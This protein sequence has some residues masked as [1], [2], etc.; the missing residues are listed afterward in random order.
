MLFPRMRFVPLVAAVVTLSLAGPPARQLPLQHR[1]QPTMPSR[2]VPNVG[3]WAPEVLGAVLGDTAAWLHA[4]GFSLRCERRA[5]R[6]ADDTHWQPREAVG[7]QLRTRF[8]GAHASLA[9]EQPQPTM[10]HFLLGADATRHR[11]HVP[12]FSRCTL[13]GIAPG[14]DVA[15]GPLRDAGAGPFAY[16]LLLA[17]GASLAEL[18]VQIEGVDE[19]WLDAAGQL[20]MRVQTEAGA[21][22][23]RHSAPVAWQDDGNVRKPVCAQF[24]LLDQHCYGFTVPAHDS[25]LPLTVDP[26][27]V[28]C[29][30]LGG[31]ATD[32][33]NDMTWLPGSGIWVAGWAGSTN[34][35][36]TTGAY[37]TTGGSDCFVARWSEDGSQLLYAT[38]F[39][40]SSSEEVRGIAVGSGREPAIVGFTS[41]TDLPLTPNAA[42]PFYAGGSWVLQVGDAFAARLSA[43]GS[44][45]LGSTYLGGTLDDVAED[46]DVDPAGNIYIAGW[47]SSPD[48]ITTPGSWQPAFGGP[49]TLQTD[50]FLTSLTADCTTRRY[51]TYVGGFAPEQLRTVD[52]DPATGQVVAAGWS[53]SADFPTTTGAYRTS[54]A[55]VI[56]FVAL[57][58]R[59]D[60]SAPLFSTYFGGADTD[61]AEACAVAND[62]TLWVGGFTRSANFTTTAGAPQQQFGG[63]DDGAIIRLAADGQSLLYSTFLGGPGAEEVRGLAVEGAEVVAVGQTTGGIPNLG[64]LL[65]PQFGGGALDGFVAW[66]T[67][68]GASLESCTYIG[69]NEQDVLS[70]V[71]LNEGLCVASGWTFASDFPTTSNA[72][73]PQVF[74]AE[75]GVVLQM[76]VLSDLGDGLA[77]SSLGGSGPRLITEGE[78]ELVAV[79]AANQTGRALTIDSLRLLLA[80]TGHGPSVLSN[81]RVYVDDPAT[82]QAQDQLVAGPLAVMVEDGEQDIALTG[83]VVPRL[84]EVQLRVVADVAA[85]AGS[86]VEVAAAI[87]RAA[88]WSVSAYGSGAGPT[89]RV[90][91]DGRVAGEVAVLGALPGDADGDGAR[92]VFDLRRIVARLGSASLQADAD[93][94]GAWT[95]VDLDLTTDALLARGKVQH[96][97]AQVQRGQFVTLR[98]VFP[99]SATVDAVLGGQSLRV[100]QV[101]PRELVLF[102]DAAQTVGTQLLQVSVG[103]RQVLAQDLM[104]L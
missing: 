12:A 77:V 91:G 82:P 47:T 89:V 13:R 34:F 8:V 62:G 99:A 101:S 24:R 57:K 96:A 79:L 15:F 35:P 83:V 18:V 86:T 71:Q 45:L 32:S 4:D 3:Q 95:I 16:D 6:L 26:G 81:L 68:Y 76:D 87:V 75:D 84:S 21:I 48:Y 9:C 50:G 80:G 39:G 49:V 14:I 19:L 10:H 29:S 90:F 54:N 70:R 97:P 28:W 61:I 102:V 27:V 85:A 88:A 100:G 36:T 37:R 74:G 38:Y 60:G 20:C 55:G 46:V 31:G 78:H 67:N 65:Q 59:A 64:V 98:G 23:L 11:T 41:S 73:Q 53:S 93:G 51:S 43:D 42:Q 92:T 56:D 25:A 44:N 7:A 63:G 2:Y 58:L 5:P 72:L 104:V 103:G 33:I 30:A 1:T 69:G 17:P 22:E 52:V 94:D 66:W 40:G